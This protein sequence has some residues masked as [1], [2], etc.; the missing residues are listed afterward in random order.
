MNLRLFLNRLLNVFY[1]NPR[2]RHRWLKWHLYLLFFGL[3][4][5]LL[6]F[7]V[8]PLL[9][10]EFDR[11]NFLFGFDWR[12]GLCRLLWFLLYYSLLLNILFRRCFGLWNVRAEIRVYLDLFVSPLILQVRIVLSHSLTVILI[13]CVCS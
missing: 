10:R 3:F 8:E 5:N 13:R 4:L 12:Y 11:I 7:L 1:V 9:Y 6:K 2:R